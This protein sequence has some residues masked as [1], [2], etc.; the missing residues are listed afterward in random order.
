MSTSDELRVGVD[1]VGVGEVAASVARFGDRYVQRV[2]TP[3]EISCCLQFDPV[4][5]D[6]G[7][8]DA[9]QPERPERAEPDAAESEGRAAPRYSYESMAARFAAKEAAVKVLR[10]E[11]ARPDW[12]SIEVH[13]TESGWCEL[14]LSGRAA[15]MAA[16]A[17]ID[18]FAVSLTHE[19]SMG[20]AVVVGMGAGRRANRLAGD[21]G[22]R[23]GRERPRRTSEE[24]A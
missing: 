15:A 3:H 1:L 9:A 17:G 22:G 24:R 6:A 19:S 16:D 10:P 5:S 7:Q 8:V 14:R 13:R 2:Y 23:P 18:R 20:A 21:S 4:L 11:G 12:R